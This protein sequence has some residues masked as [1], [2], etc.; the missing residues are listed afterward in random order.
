MRKQARMLLVIAMLVLGALSANS[1]LAVAQ[2]GGDSPA[3]A[4]DGKKLDKDK[5]TLRSAQSVDLTRNFARLPLHRGTLNGETVWF[6]ITDVSDESIAKRLRLNFAPRLRNITRG[7]PN[8]AQVVKTSNKLLGR[9]PVEFQGAP[10]FAPTRALKA[11]VRGFPP[12]TFR[13][14]AEAYGAYSPFVMVQGSGVVFNAP[15]IATGDAPFDVTRHTNTHD[16]VLAIDPER[17]TADVLFVEGFANGEPI[18]YLSFEASDALTATI[19]RVTFVPA[20][21]LTHAERR[22]AS[23]LGAGSDLCDHQRTCRHTLQSAVAG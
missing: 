17:M 22:P 4:P 1:L 21:A 13:P 6:V 19:E 20:L 8:C 16:R 5:L 9:A 11:G 7:C 3:R 2:S 18:L 15:I 12:T 14:G 10:N 23:E